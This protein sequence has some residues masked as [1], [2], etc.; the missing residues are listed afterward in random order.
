MVTFSSV[1]HPSHFDSVSADLASEFA[2]VSKRA[3]F[4]IARVCTD[5]IKDSWTSEL[6]LRVID[7]CSIVSFDQVYSR[8][9]S[10]ELTCGG[11]KETRVGVRVSVRSTHFVNVHRT[12][13][14]TFLCDCKSSEKSEKFHF[15]CFYSMLDEIWPRYKCSCICPIHTTASVESM[16]IQ[17]KRKNRQII[18]NCFVM[19]TIKNDSSLV[20]KKLD[21]NKVINIKNKIK[22]TKSKKK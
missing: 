6:A 19:M 8:L 16:T 15:S 11:F 21:K 13:C 7:A 1:Q 10:S 2:E 22:K 4:V 9:G 12:H 5:R 14:S 3:H 20:K 17:I 18:I